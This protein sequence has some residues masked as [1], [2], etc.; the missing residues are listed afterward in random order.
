MKDLSIQ[1]KLAKIAKALAT[2]K[3]VELDKLKLK[4]DDL[5]RPDF[6]WHYLLQSFATMG[7][8]SG[9]DGLIGDKKNYNQLKYEYLGRLTP[10][11]R[12]QHVRRMCAK[13]KLR[14]PNRKT[15]YILRCF[16]QISELGGP[17]SAKQ[18]L[19][20]HKG[21]AAK[22]NFLKQFYG[23]GDKYA[24]NIMMD[25]YHE[26][27]RDSIAVDA[28]IKSFSASIGLTFDEYD[29]YEAFYKDV[30]K[31]AGINAWELDRI[32][33]NFRNEFLSRM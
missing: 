32:I 15:K 5:K 19:L 12:A 29:Q 21:K 14:M 4:E 24:R 23:I 17:K 27:F 30:A 18:K 26:E 1:K 7:R 9:W 33:F 31:R 10:E 11:T 13:A 25:V 22:I 6:L 28:R 3:C 16:E 8:V 20:S 2:E